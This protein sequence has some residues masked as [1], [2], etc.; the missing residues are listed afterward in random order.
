VA[1]ILCSK[2]AVLDYD[3][4]LGD[5]RALFDLPIGCGAQWGFGVDSNETRDALIG[6][7]NKVGL[8]AALR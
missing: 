4:S 7:L 2:A 3:K 8:L 1:R 6:A 5:S